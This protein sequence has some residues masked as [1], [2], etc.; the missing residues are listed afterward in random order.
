MNWQQWNESIDFNNVYFAYEEKVVLNN[1]SFSIKKGETIAF[2]G[3]SGSGK[4]TIVDLL[5]KFYTANK[6][7]ILIDGK[8]FGQV[9]K[10]AWRAQLGMVNQEPLLFFDSI[11]NNISLGYPDIDKEA[12]HTAANRANAKS[13]IEALPNQYDTIIGSRGTT[14][15][16]GE[17]QRITIARALLHEPDLLIFD[18][19]TASLDAQSEEQVQNAILNLLNSDRTAVVIAHRLSTIKHADKII[20][21][22]DGKIAEQ[23]NHETLLSNKGVYAHLLQLQQNQ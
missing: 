17:K 7:Q 21:L 6:G 1:I 16:G 9:P 14:L 3:P 5:A 18:E 10:K 11:A 19:A 22:K 23:G 15:S 13:F 12:I 20:V 2:V 8:D 4:S